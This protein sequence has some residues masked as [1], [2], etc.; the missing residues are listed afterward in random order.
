MEP[1]NSREPNIQKLFQSLLNS[2]EC[3]IWTKQEILNICNYSDEKNFKL[4][5][6][7]D[8]LVK[9]GLIYSMT[10]FTDNKSSEISIYWIKNQLLNKTLLSNQKDQTVVKHFHQF[11]VN[12]GSF[13]GLK[14]S[15][16][17]E[18]K[19]PELK[20]LMDQQ[21]N[22]EKDIINMKNNIQKI[23][24]A[25][26]YEEKDEK[27]TIDELIKKWRSASQEAAE[28]LHSKMPK[29][30]SFLEYSDVDKVDK[31]SMTFMLL[32]MGVDLDSIKWNQEDECFEDQ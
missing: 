6:Y 20:I 4:Q 27:N 17:I 12:G 9:D 14:S 7:L 11:F 25:M 2:K 18:R 16:N 23:Q 21:Y 3:Q 24:L 13:N 30:S 22:L 29:R 8:Q 10:T 31:D 15:I 32:N 5:T 28:L 19:H 1:N 26:S